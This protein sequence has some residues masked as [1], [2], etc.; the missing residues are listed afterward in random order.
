[1][2]ALHCELTCQESD[3]SKFS[4]RL[5]NSDGAVRQFINKRIGSRQENP[6]A[7]PTIRRS[8][9]QHLPSGGYPRSFLASNRPRGSFY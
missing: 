8:L 6:V 4:V 1:M 2:A 7:L 5:Q 9:Y 3:H